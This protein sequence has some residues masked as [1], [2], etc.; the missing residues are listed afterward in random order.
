M[1][2]TK[3]AL[4]LFAAVVGLAAC[5]ATIANVVEPKHPH[6]EL[7]SNRMLALPGQP[8]TLTAELVGGRWD[9]ETFYCPRVVWEWPDGTESSNEPDCIPFAPNVEYT[10]RWTKRGSLAGPGLY[11]FAVRLEKPKGHVVAKARIELTA[12]GGE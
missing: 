2:N 7:R 4:A 12:I 8:I 11:V 1:R 10:R 5:G 6:L 3:I 9:D